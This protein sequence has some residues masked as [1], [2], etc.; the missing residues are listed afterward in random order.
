MWYFCSHHV[1]TRFANQLQ[2]SLYVLVL[3][4]KTEAKIRKEREKLER[5]ER[6]IRKLQGV[7]EGRKVDQ[8]GG[9]PGRMVEQE[10]GSQERSRTSEK[11]RLSEERVRMSED[12]MRESEERMRSSE[13]RI[14]RSEEKLRR[15]ER[16]EREPGSRS[17]RGEEDRLP[18]AYQSNKSQDSS[19]N[20][21]C[22]P[23]PPPFN[24]V[25]EGC[26]TNVDPY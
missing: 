22:S 26:E 8:Y 7:G 25:T 13:E 12:R 21:E 3:Q 4:D 24:A 9:E 14:M 6:R 15:G 17:S 10:R 2:C 19:D 18:R 23:S 11:M 20:E 1:F 5:C 16:R